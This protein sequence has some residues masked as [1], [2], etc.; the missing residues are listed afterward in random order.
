MIRAE[1]GN[2]SE[3]LNYPADTRSST[4]TVVTERPVDGVFSKSQTLYTLDMP[5]QSTQEFSLS[6]ADMST[7]KNPGELSLASEHEPIPYVI[8]V[9]ANRAM[10]PGKAGGLVGAMLQYSKANDHAH[11]MSIGWDDKKSSTGDVEK[12]KKDVEHWKG[13][14]NRPSADTELEGPQEVF[15]LLRPNGKISVGPIP[16]TAEEN[17]AHYAAISNNWYWKVFHGLPETIKV[18]SNDD[19]KTEDDA[20]KWEFSYDN[21]AVHDEI[22]ERFADYYKEYV[23]NHPAIARDTWI[24]D[25]HLMLLAPK[26]RERGI[27]APIGQ[28]MHIPFPVPEMLELI[29]EKLEKEGHPTLHPRREILEGLMGN[30]LVGF[31]TIFD[32]VNFLKCLDANFGLTHDQIEVTNNGY[33]IQ[34]GDRKVKIG[35]YGISVDAL[36]IKEKLNTPKVKD[37]M[38]RIEKEYEG[39]VVIADASRLDI[40]KGIEEQLMAYRIVLEKLEEKDLEIKTKKAAGIQVKD[41]GID[42]GELLDKL[43]FVRIIAPSRGAVPGYEKT[44]ANAFQ[45]AKEI[46]EQFVRRGHGDKVKIVYENVENENVLALFEAKTTR[47]AYVPPKKDG[48]NLVVLE[49]GATNNKNLRFVVGKGA[50]V[51]H[52][53]KG[54][55]FR[56]EVSSKPEDIRTLA[57]NLLAALTLPDEIAGRWKNDIEQHVITNSVGKWGSDFIQD[58]HAMKTLNA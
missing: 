20:I 45:L 6:V 28:F 22:N 4:G 49:A 48:M 12:W 15:G 33:I 55:A 35:T 52:R 34:W 8:D 25:Y 46:N 24:H 42:Y 43:A 3:P 30:D 14:K 54:M 41:T 31:Q 23:A 27:T 53:L 58:L 32:T 36:A 18:E 19:N 50:G 51:S 7:Q 11:I 13:G 1:F 5:D 17:Q 26:L 29:P 16:I 9:I 2:F 44:K 56:P 21:Y 10:E 39:K 38:E 47:V 37:E 40:T 57:R